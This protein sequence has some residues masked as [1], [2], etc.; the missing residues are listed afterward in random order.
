MAVSSF[1]DIETNVSLAQAVVLYVLV[2]G[3][4]LT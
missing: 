3:F 4:A 2:L 1:T